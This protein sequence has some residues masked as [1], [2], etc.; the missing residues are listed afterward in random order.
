MVRNWASP[1]RSA[2][3]ALWGY[4]TSEATAAAAAGRNFMQHSS[5]GAAIRRANAHT[6][7]SPLRRRTKAASSFGLAVGGGAPRRRHREPTALERVEEG[8]QFCLLLAAQVH[9]ETLVVEI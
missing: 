6:R 9:A 7:K 2:A 3:D 8:N 4:R 5:L 1:G